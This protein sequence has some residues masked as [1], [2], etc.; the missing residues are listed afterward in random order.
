MGY[1]SSSGAS[2]NSGI[3]RVQFNTIDVTTS[4]N[5]GYTDNTAISTTVTQGDTHNLAVNVNTNGNYTSYVVAWIDWNQNGI[6]EAS[7]RYQLGTRNNSTNAQP[8]ASPLAI[9]VPIV[10]A[11]GSTRMRISAN[12]QSGL[13]YANSCGSFTYGE[14][15]DYTVNI[16]ASCTPPTPTFTTSPSADVCKNASVTY[17]TQSGKTNYTWSIPGLSGTDYTITGGGT[18]TN[19]VTLTWLTGGSKTVTVGYT[20]AGCA[21]TTPASNTI[22]V[23]DVSIAPTAIQN[24]YVNANGTQLTAT[25]QG[26]YT[27][28]EWKYS[29]TSGSGY[30]SFA[31]PQTGTTY[32][33]NFNAAN[34]YYVVCETVFDCGTIRSNE[35]RIN[36]TAASFSGVTAGAGTEPNTISSLIT[37]QSASSL[38]FDFTVTDDAVTTNGNDTLPTL[39][40]QILI[41]QGTGND[42]TDW[43]QAIVGAELSDGTNSMTGTIN[44]T[45]I[46]FS[47]I[48]T[49]NLGR[50][51]DG[52]TKTYTL[53]VWLRN[54]MLGTLPATVDGSNLAFRIDRTNFT[55]AAAATST[56]FE[57]G[58]GTAVESGSTKN[59]ITVVAT[60][61]NFVQQPTNTSIN[62]AITPAVTVSA[63]DANGNRDRD[64]TGQIE[65]VSDGT[66][67]GTSTTEINAVNG[68]ATFSNLVHTATGTNLQLLAGY[69]TWDVLSNEFDITEIT[70]VNGDYRT[71]GS[72]DWV[73]NNSTPAIWQKYNGTTWANSNSPNYNTSNNVYIREGHT[74]TT[75]GSFGNS[76]KFHIL[77]TLNADHQATTAS[78]HVYE[79]GL[80]KIAASFT[81]NGDFIIDNNGT[82][83]LN[84]GQNNYS[85]LWSGT[86]K[87]GEN[88]KFIVNYAHRGNLLFTPESI[89]STNPATGAKFGNLIIQPTTFNEVNTHWNGI[90]PTGIYQITK[91]NLT[92]NNNSNRRF[93]L[94]N[95]GPSD[96][97]IGG[98]LLVNQTTSPTVTLSSGGL[99][100]YRVLGNVITNGSSTGEFTINGG[101]TSTLH[102]DGNLTINT[103]TF[104]FGGYQTSTYSNLNL[105]G[106]FELGSAALLINSS[107]NYTA[108]NQ[109]SFNGSG[110]IQTINAINQSTARYI[111]F[112]VDS[113]AYVKLI[114]QNFSLGNSSAFN[115]KSGGTL[116]F[117]FNG[118]DGSGNTAL[119]IT[120]HVNSVSFTT[121]PNSTIKITSPEGITT[122]TGAGN[123]RTMITG[124]TFDSGG[125]YH[126]LGKTA[127]ATGNGLPSTG[128]TGKVIVDLETSNS[129]HDNV[130][131]TVTGTNYFATAS[132][133][134]G[135][136]EIRR[137][138]VIDAPGAGFRNYSGTTDENQ[139]GESDTHKGDV[140]M[141]GG[142]YVVSG[143]GTKPS[144]SGNYNLTGGTVEF[145]GN[146]AST[147]IRVKPTYYNLVSSGNTITSGGKNLV[148]NNLT[149][150]TAGQLTIPESGDSEN[151]Y[152]LTASKG[153]R[154]TGGTALFAN[155][156]QLMQDEEAANTGAIT[157]VRKMIPRRIEGAYPAGEYNFFSSPVKDQNMKM[158]YGNNP[159]NTRYVL[160]LDEAQNRFVNAKESDYLISSKGFAVK[161]PKATFV[162]EQTSVDATFLG[163]PNNTTKPI[164]VTKS[165]DNRGWNLVG[166]PYPSNIDLKILYG[167]SSNIESEFRFWDNTVN[168]T[169]TYDGNYNQ[170]SYALYNANSSPEGISNPAPG[171]DDGETLPDP[172]VFEGEKDPSRYVGVGQGF[173][174]KALSPSGT[175]HFT[176]DVRKTSIPGA[177]FFGRGEQSEEDSYRLRLRTPRGVLLYQTVVYFDGGNYAFASGDSKHP[178]LSSS[179]VFYSSTDQQKLVINSRG[180]F[181]DEDVVSL[182][183]KSHE[184]GQY[185]ISLE[186]PVGKFQNEQSVYLKDKELNI[187]VNLTEGK[188]DFTTESGEFG[189]RFEII[190]QEETTLGVGSG[191]KDDIL[192]YPSGTGFHVKSSTK[193]IDFIELYSMDGR[194]I[195]KEMVSRRE[196]FLD[197][198][199]IKQ[200][201]YV[202]KILRNG[203]VKNVKV[204]R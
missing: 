60:Q 187:L 75:G 176:N 156:A 82:V 57:T 107:D 146:A 3:L 86:E 5:P 192:V 136:L 199:Y 196:T 138:R 185:S 124:R 148:V 58:T 73:N 63:N 115:V 31:T 80:L 151:P 14:V 64:F 37:T 23:K 72:G 129:G 59:E 114:N 166:N 122:S 111:T 95:A 132:G 74:I 90:F 106:N 167:Q 13:G 178:G 56:Q 121:E 69:G 143:G 65:I 194:L 34:T 50:V 154:V 53:K 96:I 29:T 40:T 10:A 46:T 9:N 24:I 139:D 98:D 137:G 175:V 44:A 87:F 110:T 140:I 172:N 141:T 8:S 30:V 195:H 71:R 173:I 184:S 51:T 99:N 135:T 20:D 133:V 188:Y 150:V 155:N 79:T 22:T 125:I 142:R 170:Y 159:E 12:T 19:S 67:S 41:P 100:T 158:L 128:V 36:V 134:N 118:I 15:E 186:K 104:R 117:G 35:V 78:I 179:D 131:F 28:R 94:N 77:G 201:L 202:M 108:N 42:I 89:I 120:E 109:F 81:N 198:P 93:T 84:G 119:N 7:E 25:T 85:S 68:L 193:S 171:Q 144:L 163:E 191:S 180:S 38:N 52:N 183:F 203:E 91:K 169:Y 168:A 4:S 97:T 83:E 21:S 174:V 47:S 112:N 2:N 32:T 61:L 17:T 123:V 43:T 1:C 66:L 147:K 62:T 181:T 11:L 49:T 33:P 189:N 45:N 165:A 6:F 157:V 162:G 105:K 197:L 18:T 101:G 182:G 200:G 204:L 153:I 149:T 127:Q 48:N 39:I 130:D 27:S 160:V 164:A 190:Y 177:F 113:G 116:D 145:T 54:P 161:E 152:V 55:T 102:I 16:I 76:V 88:S 126:Y 92:I 103:G 26:T 70:Y